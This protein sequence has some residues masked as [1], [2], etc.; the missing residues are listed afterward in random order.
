MT[1]HRKFP[2][3]PPSISPNENWG[4]DQW[5]LCVVHLGPIHRASVKSG[6]E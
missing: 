1:T 2:I 3:R 6:Q 5:E 4:H